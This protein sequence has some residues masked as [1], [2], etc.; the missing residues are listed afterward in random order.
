[1]AY[2]TLLGA[3][4]LGVVHREALQARGFTL[5]EIRHRRYGTLRLQGRSSIC[6]EL[7]RR[8]PDMVDGVPGFYRDERGYR[9]AG[10]PGLLIP[11]C[12]P[13]GG[14]RGLR[15]RPDDAGEGGKYRW[16]SSTGKPGGVGS[17]THCH[18]ARPRGE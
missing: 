1:N 13:D 9:L 18:V 7:D 6:K 8:L 14:I 10:S 16:L 2:Q 12:G 15:I 17:G 4:P 11:A 3:C 5:D